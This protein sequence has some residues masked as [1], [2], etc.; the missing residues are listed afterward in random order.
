MYLLGA[1]LAFTPCFWCARHFSQFDYPGGTEHRTS[2]DPTADVRSL[3]KRLG[4][5][6]KLAPINAV[7][8]STH[9]F[10][11]GD[12]WYQFDV[13]PEEMTLL[14]T[15][16]ETRFPASGTVVSPP[17]GGDAPLWWDVATC[18]DLVSRSAGDWKRWLGYSRSR[19]RIFYREIRG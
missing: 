12:D 1:L 9:A 15:E 17:S 14:A 10:R 16:L 19:C 2:A 4:I 13:S 6:T 11:G 3:L 5:E 8:E 18:P 7:H